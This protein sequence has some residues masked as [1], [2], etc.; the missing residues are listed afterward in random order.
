MKKLYKLVCDRCYAM[1]RGEIEAD[2]LT[3]EQSEEEI[4]GGICSICNRVEGQRT[5]QF[6][7]AEIMAAA[8]EMKGPL[9]KGK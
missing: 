6:T 5:V 3:L 4:A 1:Y 2:G 9:G 8:E 7:A